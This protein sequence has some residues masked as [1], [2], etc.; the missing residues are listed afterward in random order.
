VDGSSVKADFIPTIVKS[1]DPYEASFNNTSTANSGN[2]QYYWTF[3]DGTTYTGKTPPVHT[4][5]DTGTYVVTLLVVDSTA[6]NKRDSIS[7]IITFSSDYVEA[8]FLGDSVCIGNSVLFSNASRNAQSYNWSFGD[9][10]TSTVGTPTHAYQTPGTY[11]VTLI[12]AHPGTCNKFDTAKQTI[13][14]WGQP[15]ADFSYDPIIPVANEPIKFTNKSKEATSYYWAFGDGTSSSVEHP[16]HLYKR[17][18]NYKVC[19]QATNQYGCMHQTC[20]RRTH[21]LQSQR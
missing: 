4:Y 12:A 10:G 17:T 6:C 16:S 19:L 9:G 21:R 7:K 2:A 14:V 8:G 5:P 18:G 15:Y 1:C 3:G 11:V 20:N 13:V